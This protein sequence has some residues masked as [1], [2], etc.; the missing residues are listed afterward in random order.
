M[1][2]PRLPSHGVTAGSASPRALAVQLCDVALES[3]SGCDPEAAGPIPG[4]T[5]RSHSTVGSV[6]SNH[7]MRVQLPS[8]VP[9]L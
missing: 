6:A 7:E 3:G 2:Q 1:A 4:V 9:A 8:P 5:R